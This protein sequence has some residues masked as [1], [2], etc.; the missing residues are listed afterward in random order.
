MLTHRYFFVIAGFLQPCHFRKSRKCC[1]CESWRSRYDLAGYRISVSDSFGGSE[2]LGYDA[3][4]DLT[5][6]TYT[7]EGESLSINFTYNQAHQQTGETMYSS[8]T[9]I[10]SVSESY[11]ADGNPTD[12][13]DTNAASGTIDSFSYAYNLADWVTSEADYSGT[14]TSYTYDNTGQLIG[15]GTQSYSLSA[16]G[17]PT[18]SGDSTTTGNELATFVDPVSGNTFDYT[19]DAAGNVLTKTDMTTSVEWTYAYDNDNNMI[20]AIETTTG[21]SPTTLQ[22]ITYEY[23]AFGN[24]VKE[25]EWLGGGT[26]TLEFAVDGWNP[27]T[28]GAL[29]LS[30]FS[31]WAI[32]NGSTGNLETRNIYGNAIDQILA[33][34][35]NASNGAIDPTGVY[36]TLT[37][38]NGSV[39]DVLDNTPNDAPVDQ[40]Y[41][42]AFGNI[43]SQTSSNVAVS[44]PSLYLGRYGYDGYDWDA[45]DQLAIDNARVYDPQSERWLE[46]DP[47]GFAAGD[48]NLYR[49]VNNAPTNATDPT[50]LA[51]VEVRYQLQGIKFTQGSFGNLYSRKFERVDAGFSG[52][53]IDISNAPGPMKTTNVTGD[54]ADVT[55]PVLTE[56]T[57]GIF[58]DDVVQAAFFHKTNA[59]IT[60]ISESLKDGMRSDKVEMVLEFYNA[61]SKIKVTVKNPGELKAG[62]IGPVE[63]NAQLGLDK[64]LEAEGNTKWISTLK[65]TITRSG[66]AEGPYKYLIAPVWGEHVSGKGISESPGRWFDFD[67]N[68]ELEHPDGDN[69]MF[70]SLWS[71]KL[72]ASTEG[73]QQ[74]DPKVTEAISNFLRRASR[75]VE[76]IREMTIPML[77]QPGR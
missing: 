65:F 70:K 43:I 76:T 14:T 32:I 4:N 39:R 55:T 20:S 53:S 29:G 63:L 45:A 77:P 22:S 34:I 21:G 7:G 48:S 51:L 64:T 61:T 49:Y 75:P 52:V 66:P 8:G 24:M 10:A 59:K 13:V 1:V 54:S 31:T 3:D 56:F 26:A 23:D 2:S 47:M 72:N 62:K 19:Y 36:W 50:G 37:D 73:V 46:Q 17:N 12:I 25:T 40:I 42:D 35:D 11:D 41:Y 6:L 57:K 15:A 16:G 44:N 74:Q 33:R 30:G 68:N 18:A 58:T 27:A 28:S 67:D 38:K 60:E 71:I 9:L 69:A 5:T